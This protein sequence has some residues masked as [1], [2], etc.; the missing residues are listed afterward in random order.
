VDVETANPKQGSN[1]PKREERKL[2]YRVASDHVTSD[3]ESVKRAEA[4][5]KAAVAQT[6]KEREEITDK[7]AAQKNAGELV[8]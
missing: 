3:Q 2:D 7:A 5:D 8:A 1:I 6:K 4:A